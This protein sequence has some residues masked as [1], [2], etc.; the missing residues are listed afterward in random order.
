MQERHCG[1]NFFCLCPAARYILYEDNNRV[2]IKR[3]YRDG[4]NLVLE[5]MRKLIICK[6]L[7]VWGLTA[8]VLLGLKAVWSLRKP[9]KQ[10]AALNI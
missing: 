8:G 5:K 9:N 4:E 2:K 1:S 6:H 3:K 7:F 10:R